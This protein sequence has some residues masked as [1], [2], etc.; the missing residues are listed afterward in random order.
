VGAD[1]FTADGSS[2]DVF[3]PEINVGEQSKTHSGEYPA[4]RQ[5]LFEK[6]SHQESPEESELDIEKHKSQAV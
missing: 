4:G 5:C 6:E 2:L 1:D 3:D